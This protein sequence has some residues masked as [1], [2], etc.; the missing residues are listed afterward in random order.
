M[1]SAG[2]SDIGS[3][4]HSGKVKRINRGLRGYTDSP[5]LQFLLPTLSSRLLIPTLAFQLSLLLCSCAGSSHPRVLGPA[6]PT[7]APRYLELYSEV[8]IATL[9]FPAGRYVLNAADKIGYYYSAPRGVA[10]HVGGGAVEREGG[11]FVSK[12]N[13]AKLR[14]YVFRAGGLTHVGNL[15]GV[16]HAF[17]D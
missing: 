11:I 2:R 1:D 7:S 17:H 12:H 10:E 8:H 16:N 3:E 13:R 9:H 15:S 14:G 5:I 6:E 4:S